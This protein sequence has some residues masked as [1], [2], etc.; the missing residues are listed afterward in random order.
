MTMATTNVPMFRGPTMLES[1]LGFAVHRDFYLDYV[2]ILRQRYGDIFSCY[3]RGWKHLLL[4]PSAVED[5]LSRSHRSFGKGDN[6]M[7][8]RHVAGNGPLISVG[9]DWVR[10][11]RMINPYLKRQALG[12]YL[13]IMNAAI[14]ETSGVWL[15]SARRAEVRD[16]TVDLSALS[17]RIAAQIFI[18][19]DIDPAIA[20]RFVQFTNL[21]LDALIRRI[22]HPIPTPI[23]F[24][25]RANRDLRA[26]KLGLDD[27]VHLILD[28]ET[29]LPTGGFVS[30][31][32]DSYRSEPVDDA[33][34]EIRDQLINIILA[35]YET[36]ANT[37]GWALH[38][39]EQHPDVA[40]KVRAEA[41]TALPSMRGSDDLPYTRQVVR[42]TL[43][44][45]PAVPYLT[46]KSL[47]PIE[48]CGREFPANTGFDVPV[49][50]MHRHPERWENPDD[51]DPERFSEA[52]Q[53]TI[54]AFGYLPFGAG[55]RECAGL[56]FA[57]QEVILA[58]ARFAQRF[59]FKSMQPIK[60][61]ASAVIRPK[62][63][64]L[65][66]VSD[67]LGSRAVSL[68]FAAN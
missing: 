19:A 38:L 4:Q 9:N 24:P 50:T 17:F 63:G 15:Q 39:L 45:Y 54:P 42:E 55:P 48:V 49:Y 46:R 51:F 12:S 61:L 14:D 34:T 65:M 16:L 66:R 1:M 58:V 8:F 43:R 5:V 67:R 62:G 20:R 60:P 53:R 29:R 28:G 57:M 3:V 13:P 30:R 52:R 41:D 44:L 18:G 27:V 10:Q 37:I 36:S 33:A 35:G 6:A 21:G 25:L 68:G 26:A 59:E 31:L 11:R 23:W 32:I 40:A 22:L 47:E 56:D 64:F 7:E 2:E